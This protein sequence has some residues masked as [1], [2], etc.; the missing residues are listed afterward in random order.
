MRLAAPTMAPLGFLPS[1]LTAE[2]FCAD[3]WADNW[4]A[5]RINGEQ[6]A[7]DSVPITTEQSFNAE[8]FQFEA[9]RPFVI[10]PVTMDFKE[11]D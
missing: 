3:V 9:E 7:E 2:T 5:L 6:V 1:A 10:G 8:S 11:N 4:F